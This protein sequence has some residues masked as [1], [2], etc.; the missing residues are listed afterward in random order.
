MQMM[1]RCSTAST[2]VR[3][4]AIHAATSQELLT[5]STVSFLQ[6]TGFGYTPQTSSL[7]IF[8]PSQVPG[9]TVFR[10]FNAPLDGSRPTSG[11]TLKI[12]CRHEELALEWN[13]PE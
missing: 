9:L 4:L 12:S 10:L 7:S 6:H 5:S 3:C 1:I 11:T 8:L 13:D 2:E